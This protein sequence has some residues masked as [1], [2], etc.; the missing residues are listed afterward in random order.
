M[1]KSYPFPFFYFK[2]DILMN[3]QDSFGEQ[4][5][6]QLLKINKEKMKEILKQSLV[7]QKIER[8][9]EINEQLLY[10]EERKANNKFFK[11]SELLEGTYY[12]IN[13]NKV[14]NK[15]EENQIKKLIFEA[16][17][18]T[19]SILQDLNLIR[20][21]KNV[22][23]FIDDDYNYVRIENFNFDINHV[24]LNPTAS[25]RGKNY[26]LRLHFTE[27]EI[28]KMK[29]QQNYEI[30]NNHFYG[31]IEPFRKYEQNNKT[32]WKIN[33]GVLAE[34]F[35]RH[36]QKNHGN[37]VQGNLPDDF[38]SE[39][40]RWWMYRESSGSDPYFTGP[41]TDFAQVKNT[42]ASL[43]SNVN[44]VVNTIKGI[45]LLVDEKNLQNM[46]N[47][48][49]EA[50][51]KQKDLKPSISKKIYEGMDEKGKKEIERAMKE[52]FG[53]DAHLSLTK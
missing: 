17:E 32:G 20:K 44:T 3:Y 7:Q 23:S 15:D 43:V 25:K 2:G 45:L 28:Q 14:Q 22:V 50:I 19:S 1:I 36:W 34:T 47:E 33:K 29:Q 16:Y 53:E 6:K 18:L 4:V 48:N 27:E 26:G 39:G 13:F 46:S 42:N 21:I 49:I 5:E 30:I 10:I 51:F 38:E 35:Q 31:F 37:Y 9:K 24:Y 8:L 11:W 41:D 40:R 52:I 12:I